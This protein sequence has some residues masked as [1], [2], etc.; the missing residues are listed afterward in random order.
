MQWQVE[1]PDAYA[2]YFHRPQSNVD[3]VIP[4]AK[5]MGHSDRVVQLVT[6]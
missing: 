3:L 6:A 2:E 5:L 4:K 1:L